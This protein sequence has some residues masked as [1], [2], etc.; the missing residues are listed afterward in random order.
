MR[1]Q[2]RY[3]VLFRLTWKINQ[4]KT[5]LMNTKKGSQSINDYFLKIKSLVDQPASVGYHTIVKY[6]ID[7]IFNGLLSNYDTFV[8]SV[9]SSSDPY[10]VAE[11]ESL[12]LSQENRIEKTLKDLDS[13]S[14]NLAHNNSTSR[15]NFPTFPGSRAPFYSP[16]FND[17][18]RFHNHKGGGRTWNPYVASDWSSFHSGRIWNPYATGDQFVF[19]S[20]FNSKLLSLNQLL[21][22]RPFH[23]KES[24]KC[25]EICS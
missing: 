10:T 11:I 3:G 8:I 15:S 14:A 5:Q 24:H 2:L 4:F 21:Q 18:Y 17:G 12:L 20:P 23:Y 22:L 9:N 13:A 1:P 7:V 16:A 25:V 19:P 6:H